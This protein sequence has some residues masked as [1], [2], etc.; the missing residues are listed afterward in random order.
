MAGNPVRT[1][2]GV[3]SALRRARQIRGI[4]LDEASRDLRVRAGQLRALED[5]EFDALDTEVYVRALLRTYAQYLRLDPAKVLGAYVRHADD[6]EPP[7]PPS[8]LGRVERALAAARVRD[9]QRF[10]LLAAV[11]I[12]VVLIV[13]GLVSRAGTPASA[14]LS[15]GASVTM[16]ADAGVDLVLVAHAPVDVAVT[17]DEAPERFA[18]TQGETRSFSARRELAVRVSDGSAIEVTVN[19]VLQ[20]P[21]S[22]SWSARFPS[23]LEVSP[24]PSE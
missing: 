2:L 15:A 6:P 8:K 17:V 9:N 10:L 13:T 19:G 3:G 23:E 20:A 11:T 21:T 14:D 12:L 4:S 1:P 18:M 7:P 16:P 22:G 24:S 5:E